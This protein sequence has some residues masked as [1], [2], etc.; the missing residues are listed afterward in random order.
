MDERSFG[1][2]V[3][4]AKAQ[5][6]FVEILTGSLGVYKLYA[7]VVVDGQGVGMSSK[8]GNDVMFFKKTQQF[9]PFFRSQIEVLLYFGRVL[10]KKG[11][12]AD[13][14]NRQILFRY[15]FQGVI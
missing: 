12:M 1:A 15:V 6:A 4:D 10:Y 3:P 14:K 7:V 11:M 2:D 13:D 9:V 5:G 8:N